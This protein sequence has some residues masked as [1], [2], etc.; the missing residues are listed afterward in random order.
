MNNLKTAE[1]ED[2]I[3]FGDGLHLYISAQIIF[4]TIK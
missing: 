4:C 1:N 3:K 2:R